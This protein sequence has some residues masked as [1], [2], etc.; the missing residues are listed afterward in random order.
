MPKQGSCF[1]LGW[2][3]SILRLNQSSS[4]DQSY[5]IHSIKSSLRIVHYFRWGRRRIRRRRLQWWG[6][7]LNYNSITRRVVQESRDWG[8]GFLVIHLQ[9]WFLLVLQNRMEI[10]QCSLADYVIHVH[11]E[12]IVH[13]SIHVANQSF[14]V[15]FKLLKGQRRREDEEL[16]T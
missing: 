8:L 14:F 12:T 1:M 11:M 16:Q 10:S 6:W 15:N 4:R 2:N 3:F 5:L 13:G 7:I 9:P